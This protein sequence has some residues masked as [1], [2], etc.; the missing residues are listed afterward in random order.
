MWRP[1]A[2]EAPPELATAANCGA[3]R[4]AGSDGRRASRTHA[5][6]TTRPRAANRETDLTGDT[7]H[8]AARGVGKHGADCEGQQPGT[9]GPCQDSAAHF[10]TQKVANTRSRTSRSEEHTSEL[11]SQSN[12]VCR[13]RLE[14]KKK[15]TKKPVV[16]KNKKKNVRKTKTKRTR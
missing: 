10:P 6:T 8:L 13:L 5:P 15:N 1:V 7:G 3:W 2:A 12:L 16:Q 11:Q 14:K 9:S 4:A